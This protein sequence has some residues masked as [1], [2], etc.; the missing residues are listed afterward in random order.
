MT[1]KKKPRAKPAEKPATPKT[2][3]E[4][5]DA[6]DEILAERPLSR[7]DRRQLARA[8]G[9]S[10]A[11]VS[12]YARAAASRAELLSSGDPRAAIVAR[13]ELI[14]D[15]AFT[16]GKFRD[17]TQ[18]LGLAL[19]ALEAPRVTAPARRR[20]DDEPLDPDDAALLDEA[21]PRVLQ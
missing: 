19:K 18:A 2:D 16:K 15:V 1:R 3:E 21:P 6:I 11:E 10:I 9:I 8:W 14:A 13:L 20:S 17:A 4:R 12:A 7:P 5:I